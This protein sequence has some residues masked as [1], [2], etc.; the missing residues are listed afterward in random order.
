VSQLLEEIRA[1]KLDRIAAGYAVAAWVVIQA[2]SIVLPTF[3]AAPWVMQFLIIASIVGFFVTVAGR[4]I[5]MP[6]HPDTSPRTRR[7]FGVFLIAGVLLAVG[8]GLFAWGHS[9]NTSDLVGDTSAPAGSNSIAVLPFVNMSGDT[10]QDYL[11]DGIAEEIL[12]DLSNTPE[13]R[14]AARTSSFAFKGRNTDIKQIARALNVRGIVEGSVRQVGQRVRI[15]A[16]LVDASNGFQIWSESYDR[17]LTDILSLQADIAHSI[18]EAVAQHF[19]GHGVSATPARPTPQAIDPEAYKA[20]LRGQDYFAQRTR[21]SI[22]RAVALFAETTKLA[23]QYADGFA[24]LANAQATAALDYQVPDSLPAAIDAVN[25]ALALDPNNPTALKAR[26]I[27]ELLQWQWRAAAA[28]LRRM[29]ELHANSASV[30]HMR[31]IFFDYMALPQFT[32]PAEEKAVQLDPLS[33]IDRYNLALYRMLEKRYDEAARISAEAWKLQPAQPDLH[34]LNIQIALG[35]ND[36]AS[37]ERTLATLVSQAGEN[38]P[39]TVGARFYIEVAKK[40]F[41]SAR[42]IVDAVAASFPASGI[43]ATDVGTAYAM[44]NDVSSATKWYRRAYELREPQFPRVPYANPQLTKLFADPRWKTLRATS[45]IR[46]W[47]AARIE[48]AQKSRRGK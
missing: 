14:V 35:Q 31:A 3:N 1:R 25:K 37:A 24:A 2:A 23:P 5:L 44:T 30:W 10:K 16:E 15:A 12:N 27:A 11:S 19:L 9:G 4:W 36:L 17:E 41:V 42:K 32:G 13:L 39:D 22:G 7:I 40:D 47:E 8:L 34:V 43:T 33:Y 46:D 18:T 20:Y 28:D 6:A 45:E 21:E 48:I 26:A 38:S 29:E